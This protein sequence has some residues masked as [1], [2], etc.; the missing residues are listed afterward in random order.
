MEKKIIKFIDDM[1]ERIISYRRDF[2]KYPEVGWTEFRTASKIARRL[3]ELGFEVKLGREVLKDEERMGLPSEE[4][5]ANQ[6]ERALNQGADEELII[7]LEGGFTGVMGILELGDGPCIGMRFDIDALKVIEDSGEDHL[8][9]RLKF[10]SENEGIMHACGHDCHAAIGLGVAETL[11]SIKN[12]IAGVGRIKLIFQP[13]EEGVRG[14][15]AMVG[16]GILDDVDYII[17]GHIGLKPSKTLV[18]GTNGFMATTKF[19]VSFKGKGAHAGGEPNEGK[20]SM[21]AACTAVLNLN[22]IPRHMAGASRIN[23]G[24][25]SS[26]TDRNVI[27][28]KSFM[29]I[30]TRGEST[31][32][33]DYMREY[34]LRIIE[35]SAKMHSIDYEVK[36]MGEAMCGNCNQVL[37]ERVN[38]VGR[39]LGCFN[40][41]V[42][43]S[44]DAGGSEDFTF[45]LN[46]VQEKGG[47]GVYFTIGTD[48]KGGHH[49][50]KFDVNE[51]DILNAVKLFVII[52]LDILEGN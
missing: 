36:Y 3:I 28:E 27:P 41:I 19:D 48:T 25:L 1:E 14:A 26:G 10:S 23:V 13:A 34:A 52:T 38:K 5:L 43:I 6:Y 30:E 11:S 12:E 15:K 33:N 4:E 32:I 9:H 45:M 51:Q 50:S 18:C 22:A 42:D 2:H 24:V 20:N 31:E 29:K 16:A 17:G 7:R 39:N 44:D 46:R 47:Q 8:P 21:L 37:V 35:T 40:N 49:N